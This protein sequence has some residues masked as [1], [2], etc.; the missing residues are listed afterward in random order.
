MCFFMLTLEINP[1]VKYSVA[2]N[3]ACVGLLFSHLWNFTCV[4]LVL[5]G[6]EINCEIP[7]KDHHFFINHLQKN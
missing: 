5:Q 1:C 2:A 3:S 7:Q 6:L 4:S